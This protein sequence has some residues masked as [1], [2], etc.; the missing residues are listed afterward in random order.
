MNREVAK[1]IVRAGAEVVVTVVTTTVDIV[2]FLLKKR[3]E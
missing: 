3:D 1:K 2:K